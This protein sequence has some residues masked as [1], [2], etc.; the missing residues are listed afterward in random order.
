MSRNRMISTMLSAA[1][2]TG[3]AVG[4]ARGGPASSQLVSARQAY[5]QAIA[6]PAPKLV[7]KE[8]AEA[9]SAL[10]DAEIAHK[11][12]AGSEHEQH[13]AYLALRRA[14]I[15]MARANAIIA[16]QQHQ[17]AQ[18]RYATLLEQRPTSVHV[19]VTNPSNADELAKKDQQLD[20][21]TKSLQAKEAELA[22][23][24]EA[25]KTEREAREKLE[26]ERDEALNKLKDFAAVVENERGTV[27]TLGGALLFRSNETVLLPT[28]QAKLDQVATALQSV[29]SDQ[30][31]VIEGHADARGS[32]DFNRRLS[33][34]RAEAVRAY[35]V[36][37]GVPPE[38][39]V[40][41]G[42]GEEQPVASNG[43]AEGRANNRRVEIVISRPK[44]A[45]K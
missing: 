22:A 26:R 34:Q 17:D 20:E 37:R 40:S 33:V 31:L 8:L 42:K 14:Q 29:G 36:S 7:P 10:N 44:S 11:E 28:A 3:L 27:I 24:A 13:Y 6:S 25:L 9:R 15:A 18:T 43:T 32:S 19:E 30:S 41:L 45:S 21:R 2:A 39:L 12:D 4:C 35:L 23:Q 5:A 38:K 1:L 16:Q